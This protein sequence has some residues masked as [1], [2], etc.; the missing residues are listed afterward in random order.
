M[1][2]EFSPLPKSGKT[3]RHVYLNANRP[4]ERS[5]KSAQVLLP[6]T[7]VASKKSSV[8]ALEYSKRFGDEIQVSFAAPSC[9]SAQGIREEDNP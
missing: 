1:R 6:S 3:G 5:R 7:L 2:C 9:D 8:A 4:C